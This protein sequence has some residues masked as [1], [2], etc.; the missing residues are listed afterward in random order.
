MIHKFN[1][2]VEKS[3]FIEDLFFDIIDEFEFTKKTFEDNFWRDV[4]EKQRGGIYFNTDEKICFFGFVNYM[5]VLV[6][7]LKS[8]EHRAKLYGYEISGKNNLLE[9][10]SDY[11]KSAIEDAISEGRFIN[12][13]ITIK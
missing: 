3:N 12:L 11:Y 6:K 1:S 4:I 9:P 13:E 2:Y 10:R 8:V 5:D 7:K